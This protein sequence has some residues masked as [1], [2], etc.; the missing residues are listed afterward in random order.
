MQDSWVLEE[1]MIVKFSLVSFATCLLPLQLLL[2]G[3]FQQEE[4]KQ[5]HWRDTLL[6][7]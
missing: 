1:G 4:D 7:T 3:S 6:T 5:P 2:T